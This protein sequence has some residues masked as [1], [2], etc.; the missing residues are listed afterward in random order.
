ME[1]WVVVVGLGGGW[2]FWPTGREE[3]QGRTLMLL[4]HLLCH[5]EGTAGKGSTGGT[6]QGCVVFMNTE[7]RS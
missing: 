3:A 2:F 5:S 1:E 4:C 7:S 6:V